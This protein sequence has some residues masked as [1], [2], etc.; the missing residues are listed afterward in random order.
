MGTLKD[1]IALSV[2]MW[3]FNNIFCN[4]GVT[5]IHITDNGMEFVNQISKELYTRCNVA[6]PITSPY[7]PAANGLMERLNRTMTEM[8][9]K[10]W[11]SRKIGQISYRHVPGTFDLMHTNQLIINPFTS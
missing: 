6:H 10:S 8:M 1:K 3:I 5:D 9:I 7:H 11:T 2:A 4:Y